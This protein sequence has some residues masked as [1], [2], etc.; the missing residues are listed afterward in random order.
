MK[1]PRKRRRLKGSA[2]AN[3]ASSRLLASMANSTGRFDLP[4]MIHFAAF[5]LANADATRLLNRC[6]RYKYANS[7]IQIQQRTAVQSLHGWRAVAP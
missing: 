7:L 3:K 4:G 2:Q 1:R 6:D 5:F